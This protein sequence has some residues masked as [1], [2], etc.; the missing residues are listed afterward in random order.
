[1]GSLV[2]CGF[3]LVK[4][5]LTVSKTRLPRSAYENFSGAVLAISSK[6]RMS[7]SWLLIAMSHSLLGIL[8]VALYE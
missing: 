4:F 1:M 3:M 2:N 7:G 6:D 5:T 8:G